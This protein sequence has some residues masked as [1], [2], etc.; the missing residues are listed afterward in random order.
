MNVGGRTRLTST[1]VNLG[2]RDENHHGESS[3]AALGYKL[4]MTEGA[5][6]V[7]TTDLCG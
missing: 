5:C 4:W 7:N 6:Y 1:S 3:F 2:V